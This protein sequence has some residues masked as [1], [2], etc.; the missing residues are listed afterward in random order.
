M[1]QNNLQP[2]L[3][4]GHLKVTGDLVAFVTTRSP[5]CILNT[6]AHQRSSWLA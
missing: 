2:L 1:P 6:T 3:P 5:K 4:V